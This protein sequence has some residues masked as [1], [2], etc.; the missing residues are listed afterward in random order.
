MGTLVVA[1]CSRWQ[2]LPEALVGARHPPLED[3]HD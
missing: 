2:T 1:T 3:E